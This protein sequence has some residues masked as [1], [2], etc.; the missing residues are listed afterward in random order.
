MKGKVKTMNILTKS[1]QAVKDFDASVVAA[2]NEFEQTKKELFAT[3]SNTV[4]AEKLGAAR[5]ALT[6]FE[7]NATKNARDIITADFA[8]ARNA[9]FAFVTQPVPDSFTATLAAIQVKGDKI[10]PFE[11][12]SFLEKYKDNY[13][14]YSAVLKALN[15]FGHVTDV[16][17]KV[18]DSLNEDITNIEKRVLDWVNTRTSAGYGFGSEYWT[19]LLTK[20]GSSPIQALGEKIADYISGNFVLDSHSALVREVN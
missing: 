12:T 3:Y 2:R 18:P 10:T 16:F 15:D 8:E 5:E 4:A 1:M 17:V 6:A 11:A 14:A 9:V 7:M 19:R 13:M 20:D